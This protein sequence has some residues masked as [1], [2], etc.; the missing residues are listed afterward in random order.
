MCLCEGAAE[1]VFGQSGDGSLKSTDDA[2]VLV[3][4]GLHDH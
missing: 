1:L 3:L 4:A 2:S